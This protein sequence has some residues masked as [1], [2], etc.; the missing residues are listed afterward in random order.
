MDCTGY[1]TCTLPKT[2][3]A[4]ARATPRQ[5]WAYCA[6]GSC[7]C[8]SATSRS[9]AASRRSASKPLGT[10]AF[11]KSYSGFLLRFRCVCPG[12]ALVQV[13]KP[14]HFLD[15]EQELS[16]K[17]FLARMPC[18]PEYQFQFLCLAHV[19]RRRERIAQILVRLCYPG[20]VGLVDSEA[21]H[22]NIFQS[23]QLLEHII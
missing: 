23:R 17:L 5:T 7:R 4:P 21:E 2:A 19:G 20:R 13:S 22:P 9:P 11:V 14:K 6:A 18:R 10:M 1:W 15:N 12:T 3:T 8:C 16:G